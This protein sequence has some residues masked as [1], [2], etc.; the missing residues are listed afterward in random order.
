[1]I[2]PLGVP[3]IG[4]LDGGGKGGL[5]WGNIMT[6]ELNKTVTPFLGHY[7]TVRGKG[8]QRS[9]KYDGAIP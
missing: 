3:G 9:L 8:V 1:M 5:G 6:Q 4:V 2:Y 7:L